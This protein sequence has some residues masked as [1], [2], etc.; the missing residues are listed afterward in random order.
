M[1]RHHASQH[2][3][4]K[5]TF[6]INRLSRLRRAYPEA[7][8]ELE[9]KASDVPLSFS[10]DEGGEPDKGIPFRVRLHF[11]V[12]DRRRFV[13]AHARRYSYTPMLT[14]RKACRTLQINAT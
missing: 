11:R 5:P 4:L 6:P 3:A 1:P 10:Y 13:L 12:W 2:L 8:Q 7:P 14:T 9:G